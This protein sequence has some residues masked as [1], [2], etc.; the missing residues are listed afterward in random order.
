MGQGFKGQHVKKDMTF[1]EQNLDTIQETQD[2]EDIM[3]KVDSQIKEMSNALGEQKSAFV[4]QLL[5]L[6]N[7]IMQIQ[8]VVQSVK[9]DVSRVRA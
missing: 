4:S 5:D 8:D 1:T 3:A 2:E 7:A 6:G 9:E